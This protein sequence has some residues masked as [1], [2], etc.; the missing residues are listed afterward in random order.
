[1]PSREVHLGKAK[2]FIRAFNCLL[3]VD[4]CHTLIDP[5]STTAYYA[6]VHCFEACYAQGVGAPAGTHCTSHDGRVNRALLQKEAFGSKAANGFRSL[7]NFSWLARYSQ[8]KSSVPG[9]G[10]PRERHLGQDPETLE[11]ARRRLEK[12][13]EKTR[14]LL[15]PNE[16]EL[17]VVA[18]AR[19]PSAG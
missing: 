10:P 6:A 9:S 18:A 13:V 16:E 8:D 1:M 15:G 5:I 14:Q 12:I 7:L 2:S 17:P 11:N 19:A 4:A 3:N